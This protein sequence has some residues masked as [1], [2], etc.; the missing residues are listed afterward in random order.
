MTLTQLESLGHENGAGTNQFGVR[1]GDVRKLAAK[2][3]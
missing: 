2:I 1:R 3:K